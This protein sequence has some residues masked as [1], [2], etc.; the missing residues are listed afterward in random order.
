[1]TANNTTSLGLMHGHYDEDRMNVGIGIV[2]TADEIKETLMQEDVEERRKEVV[3]I[4]EERSA[5]VVA[6]SA[7]PWR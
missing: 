4:C 2:A 1:M 5:N 3:R 7:D 6:D